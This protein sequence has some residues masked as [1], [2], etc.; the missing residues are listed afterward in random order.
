MSESTYNQQINDLHQSV[1]HANF[2]A[3]KEEMK[4]NDKPFFS[5][6]EIDSLKEKWFMYGLIAVVAMGVL[7]VM[8][9]RYWK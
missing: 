1:I 5:K 7:V 2:A 4:L 6:N 9:M 3:K 8:I